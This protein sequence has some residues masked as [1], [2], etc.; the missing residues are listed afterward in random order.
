MKVWLQTTGYQNLR[1]EQKTILMGEPDK[2]RLFNLCILIGK[3][4]IHVYQN[5]DKKYP[6]SSV[7]F[8]NKL[9]LERENEEIFSIQNDKL[10][11]YE[12][13]WERYITYD[14]L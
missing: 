6:Y 11:V 9:E 10:E 5:R 3:K 14:Q 12:Y 13:K 8:E 2:D 7:H 4:L 1:I